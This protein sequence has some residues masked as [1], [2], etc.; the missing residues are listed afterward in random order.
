MEELRVAPRSEEQNKENSFL[1]LFQH[2]R[3]ALI[4]P[5]KLVEHQVLFQLH[6]RM[7]TSP[8]HMYAPP[9]FDL[10]KY[11]FTTPNATTL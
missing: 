1:R 6:F 11:F 2:V 8:A 10:Q 9:Q 4:R 7:C 3:A 5:C